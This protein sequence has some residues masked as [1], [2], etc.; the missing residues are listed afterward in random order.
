MQTS[1]NDRPLTGRTILR[2]A[3]AHESGGGTERYLDD[4]DRA[5]LQRN[6]MT[7][8]R[9]GLTDKQVPEGPFVERAGLGTLVR[10]FLPTIPTTPGKS[11]VRD[12]TWRS[13]LKRVIRDQILYNP[14]AW[15][16]GT[17]KWLR[18]HRLLLRS[19]EAVAAGAA[20]AALLK[21]WPVDL[22]VLH[23]FGGGDADEILAEARH[24]GLAV[25]ILNHYSNDR[26]LNLPIRKHAMLADGVA[27]VNGIDVPKYLE[28]HFTN[29][30][31]GI[32]I[33]F[34]RRSQARPV[35][36]AP[37]S[38]I[39]LLPARITPEKG[40][41]DLLRAGATL[42]KSGTPCSVVF[43]GRVD[44]PL[45][46][47]E[48]RKEAARLKVS[49]FVYFPGALNAEEL[50]DWYAASAVVALP[51]YHHEGLGRALVEAESMEVP[52][53]AY[54]IGGV[55][56]GLVNGRTGH[57][58]KLG[59]TDGLSQ[60]IAELINDAHLRRT[61]GLEGRQFAETRFSLEA[62]AERHEAFYG[63]LMAHSTNV[64]VRGDSAHPC[65]VTP[66]SSQ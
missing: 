59:D 57:L 6:A 26:F 4:V 33:E 14:L 37:S 53:I 58:V 47:D 22:I 2:F 13:W 49:E 11:A 1:I 44:S 61:M 56:E 63:Q 12:T 19:G 52:V 10:H 34:F 66:S 48:L 40:Q 51:T 39:I 30:S 15:K 36:S 29:L 16:I 18:S 21:K 65:S 38:P 46:V 54:A 7:I 3:H 62:L 31:D 35:Q 45:F 42:I 60:K 9:L 55:P 43:A 28:G 17:E 32:D 8:V 50:R 27:G 25:G 20:T 23:F 64:P 5:L 24:R 41:M